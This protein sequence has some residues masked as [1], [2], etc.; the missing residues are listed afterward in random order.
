MNA[1]DLTKN[2]FYLLQVGTRDDRD[3]LAVALDE[4]LAG[5]P[6][7]ETRLT[8]AF[9]ALMLPLLRLQAE[10]AWLGGTV[11]PNVV[12]Q[13]L[14]GDAPDDVLAGLSPL[15][16][17]NLAAQ[18][19]AH[20]DTTA[21]QREIALSCLARMQAVL[22]PAAIADAIND[23]RR[24]AGFP[25]VTE[26]LVTL[27]LDRLRLAHRDSALLAVLSL[28]EPEA[29]MTRLLREQAGGEHNA[30]FL[31]AL[32]EAFDNAV[33][34][35]ILEHSRRVEAALLGLRDGPAPSLAQLNALVDEFAAWG[36]LAEPR[37]LVLAAHLR[38][39][40]RSLALG[41]GLRD[42]IAARER[43]GDRDT[44][45]V[46]A[47]LGRAAF[48]ALP[49]LS[50]LLAGDEARLLPAI[51][52]VAADAPVVTAAS[53]PVF[54]APET[55]PWAAA[56]PIRL[57]PRRAPPLVPPRR[58]SWLAQFAAACRAMLE[59]R[60]GPH[61][62][63]RIGLMVGVAAG[64]FAIAFVAAGPHS[65]ARPHAEPPAGRTAAL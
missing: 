57:S 54:V 22:D 27:G 7:D 28:P 4:A 60:L 10:L 1:F 38:D 62:I 61:P 5:S 48:G 45:L 44:A 15:A 25:P 46:L 56:A 51:A 24:A 35:D 34:P 29:T 19:C 31:D 53:T 50:A 64:A 11:S 26:R 17:A 42:A 41:A 39:E 8:A 40:P 37:Q 32:V 65:P 20:G 12:R 59:A 14:T 47:R 2:P 52:P 3:R 13:L 49:G 23:D 16:T 6:N 21:G 9:H 36:S 30:A 18:L 55:R 58:S 43:L 63:L 33:L